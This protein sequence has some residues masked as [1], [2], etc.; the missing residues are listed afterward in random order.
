[1]KARVL[2]HDSSHFD[3]DGLG[4]LGE[5]VLVL[6]ASAAE[7]D[8]LVFGIEIGAKVGAGEH[9]VVVGVKPRETD[10]VGRGELFEQCFRANGFDAIQRQL[11]MGID[12]ARS[13]I[14]K[15][16]AT[17]VAGGAGTTT[18][19]WQATRSRRD[20]VVEGDQFAGL[21]NVAGEA[22]ITSL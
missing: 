17:D 10:A 16:S 18:G 14:D 2:H 3:D 19:V 12:K 8:G 9:G 21:D 5:T 1:M 7:G 4:T 15:E 20:I 6:C 11:M 22:L 13:V